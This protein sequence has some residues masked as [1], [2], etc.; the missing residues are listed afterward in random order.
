MRWVTPSR[1][2]SYCI[3]V[4]TIK[5]DRIKKYTKEKAI[6]NRSVFFRKIYGLLSIKT[7][8]L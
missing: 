2:A 6:S 1:T 7:Y 4:E 5:T 3:D 8:L